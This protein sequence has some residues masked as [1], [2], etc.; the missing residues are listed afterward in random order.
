MSKNLFPNKGIVKR[1]P[2]KVIWLTGLSGSGKSTIANELELALENMGIKSYVLD[3]DNLRIGLN[4]DLGFSDDDRKENMRRI[5]ETAKLFADSG[6]VTI[7][8]FISPFKAERADCKEIIGANNFVE[9][10]VNTSLEECERRD[11]KGL[12]A[13]ARA[14]VIP[15]FTGIDSPYEEPTNPD[16]VLEA[17][18][19]GVNECVDKVLVQLNLKN[20]DSWS[21]KNH[22]G[23]PTPNKDEKRAIFV[24]RYQPYHQGHI[25]LVQQKLDEGIPALIIVRDI[26]PDEKNPFTTEQTVSMIEKYHA[27]KGDDVEVI[28]IP[29]IESVN[30]G[31]GVG[32]E[33]NE[34]TPPENLGWISA[35]KIRQSIIDGNSDWK[36]LVDESIQ[37]DVANYL[38]SNVN[39]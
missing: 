2:S 12:Y 24:G 18:L 23:N 30:Y 32:Y 25:S 36:K 16:I 14:G 39:E 11:T 3:G 17:G 34:F 26:Q 20:T 6:T 21:K 1:E 37:E 5:A 35:T 10:H 19:F 28:V 15:N 33:I 4:K 29:D 27:S 31:R 13:K 22:G 38:I 8:A 9:C 7:A